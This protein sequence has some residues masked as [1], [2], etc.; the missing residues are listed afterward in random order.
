MPWKR[1]KD[2]QRKTFSP[3]HLLPQLQ[4][5]NSTS[6]ILA[7]L[8]QQVQQLNQSQISDERLTKWLDPTVKVLYTLSGTL[9]TGV[10]LVCP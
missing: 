8:E 2:A 4:A 1:T 9:G 5:C 3:T 10:S 6:S 7:V